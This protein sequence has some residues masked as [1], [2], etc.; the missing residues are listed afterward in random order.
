MDSETFDLVATEPP[1]KKGRDFHATPDSL[2]AGAKFE[3]RWSW[4]KDVHPDWM[5]AIKDNW[6]RRYKAGTDRI[7]QRHGRVSVLARGC[8]SWSVT[9]S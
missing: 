8:G 9:A 7:W 1:F 6:P 3:D 4:D 2:A 5:D